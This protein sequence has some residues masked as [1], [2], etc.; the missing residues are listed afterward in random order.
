MEATKTAIQQRR[1]TAKAV[2]DQVCHILGMTEEEHFFLRT[3]CMVEY[4]KQYLPG[5][6]CKD[7]RQ[8]LQSSRYFCKWWNNHWLLRDEEFLM[9]AYTDNGHLNYGLQTLEVV[10][11]MLHNPVKLAEAM[12]PNGIV[13]ENSYAEMIGCLQTQVT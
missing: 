1:D 5:D 6:V 8:Q 13:L 12:T 3:D 4:L 11:K 2:V 9:L 7:D 10:Y